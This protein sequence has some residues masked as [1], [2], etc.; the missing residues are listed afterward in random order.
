MSNISL[1]SDILKELREHSRTFVK[2]DFAY[3]IASGAIFTALKITRPEL[4]QVG[5]QMSTIAHA[6]ILLA[7]FDTMIDA[8]VFNDWFASRT[9][10]IRRTSTI[11]IKFLLQIQPFLHL[12]FVTSMIVYFTGF[13]TGA[14]SAL[15]Q[16]EGRVLLQEEVEAFIQKTG[17]APRSLSELGAYSKKVKPVLEKLN[18]EDVKIEAT[19]P[20]SYRIIFAGWDKSFGTDDDEVVTQEFL[21]RKAYQQ[22]IPD[23]NSAK[24]D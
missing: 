16:I 5:A 17:A 4:I 13:S 14:S 15:N 19:G 3:L 9:N 18:G 11:V 10:E 20:K 8:I 12:T 2:L 22:M 24:R 23:S 1:D 7:F 6:F 21:L